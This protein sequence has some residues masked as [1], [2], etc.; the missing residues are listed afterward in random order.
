M[1]LAVG[2]GSLQRA[3]NAAGKGAKAKNAKAENSQMNRLEES[4]EAAGGQEKEPTENPVKQETDAVS[5]QAKEPAENPVKQE[6]DAAK[7]KKVKKETAKTARKKSLKKQMA[8]LLTVPAEVLQD[9]PQA[10]RG[11]NY[12]CPNVSAL[13]GSISN[14]GILEPVPVVQTGENTY[15]TVG[16]SKRMQVVHMLGIAQVPVLVLPGTSVED[17]WK[18]YQELHAAPDDGIVQRDWNAANGAAEGREQQ[19]SGQET[20]TA[21]QKKDRRQQE[22]GSLFGKQRIPEYLL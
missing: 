13:A 11:P 3:A 12:V 22:T 15:Q 18:L 7:P 5:G 9:I 10:W 8:Y 16:G 19:V 6:T 2:K 20:Q 17:A 4:V 14:C 1:N 21:G